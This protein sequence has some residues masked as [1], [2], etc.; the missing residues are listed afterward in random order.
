MDRDQTEKD[1]GENG[2]EE[3]R[4]ASFGGSLPVVLC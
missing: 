3:G 1:E 4:L 2:S